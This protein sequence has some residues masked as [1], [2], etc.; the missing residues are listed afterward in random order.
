MSNSS[1]TPSGSASRATD[2]TAIDIDREL[3]HGFAARFIRHK[4]RQLVGRAGFTTADRADLDQELKLRLWRRFPQF[5]PAKSDWPAFV[6]TVVERH[7]ATLL[8]ARRRRKRGEHVAVRSLAEPTCNGD[9]H[10]VELGE[11]I[12]TEQRE[13]LTGTQHVPDTARIEL[14]QDVAA[15]LAQL[16]PEERELC[17]LLQTRSL[18]EV[19]RAKNVSR[20]TL[21]ALLSRCR[22]AFRQHEF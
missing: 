1:L 19:A 14:V 16:S 12:A 7:V 20:S 21:T 17:E 8:E 6:V 22:D 2:P 15:V 11:T 10:I 18:A 5:D 13:A 3:E 9:G 4:T